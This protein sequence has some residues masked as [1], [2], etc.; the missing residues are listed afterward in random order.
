LTVAEDQMVVVQPN[1]VA[2][3]APQ[4]LLAT[5]ALFSLFGS[6]IPSQ[7][8][9]GI[10]VGHSRV[11]E[12]VTVGM[13]MDGKTSVQVAHL[14]VSALLFLS[15][16]GPWLSVTFKRTGLI[17]TFASLLSATKPKAQRI[18]QKHTPQSLVDVLNCTYRHPE[19]EVAQL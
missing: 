13:D 7:A 16:V 1:S 2:A 17:Q 18:S 3:Q 12:T 8:S 11:H 10:V 15:I 9:S 5:F 4:Y 19:D 14:I 6:S